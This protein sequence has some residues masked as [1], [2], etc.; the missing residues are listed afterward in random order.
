VWS[1]FGRA[2]ARRVA[3]GVAIAI[4]VAM[5]L[6]AQVTFSNDAVEEIQSLSVRVD[7]LGSPDAGRLSRLLQD[8]IN[9]ELTRADLLFERGDPRGGD[10]CL[11]RLEVRLGTGTGR[12]RFGQSYSSRLE[13]GFQDRLGNVPTWTVIWAGRTLSNIIE[14]PDLTETLRF[15]ARELVVDFI[16]LYRVH[17]PRH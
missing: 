7:V 14:P 1:V 5:P 6:A 16:D 10:C 17:F 12:S 2:T 13:L 8:V 4:G 11:L 3:A 9:Q 15:V